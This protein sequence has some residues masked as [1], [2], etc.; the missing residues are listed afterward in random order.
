MDVCPICHSNTDSVRMEARG[1]RAACDTCGEY[2]IKNEC[3]DYLE[4]NAK[5]SLVAKAQRWLRESKELG[6]RMISSAPVRMDHSDVREYVTVHNLRNMY[7]RKGA[8]DEYDSVLR[9][10]L[11]LQEKLGRESVSLDEALD[12]FPTVDHGSEDDRGGGSG[13]PGGERDG[14]HIRHP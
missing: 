4:F 3:L 12:I 8:P 9:K 6:L 10:C 2:V 11:A 14:L 13:K 5:D 1:V 7:L